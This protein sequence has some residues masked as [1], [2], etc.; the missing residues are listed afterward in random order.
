M[1]LV[2]QCSTCTSIAMYAYHAVFVLQLFFCFTEA[3]G[4]SIVGGKESK[5]HSKAYMAS[6]QHANGSHR[7]GGILIRK[8]FVLTAAHCQ[9]K[10]MTVILG[11]HN[12]S[13]REKS[14]QRIKVAEFHPYPNYNNESFHNDIMLLKLQQNAQLNTYIKVLELPKKKKKKNLPANT[15]CTVAGWG[16]TV[17]GPKMGLVS[18]VLKEATEKIEY[19]KCKNIWKRRFQTERMICTKH[20]Q[21]GSFCWGDSGGPLIC[22]EN[23]EGIVSYALGIDC[24]DPKYPHVF[25]KVRFFLPWIQKVMQGKTAA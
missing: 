21:N 9:F 8:D 6:L 22:K 12:I 20:G 3:T 25:T 23:L 14:Q 17:S 10:E 1:S 15:K 5:P 19:S 11:A 13:Q 7:C 4:S 2:S 24:S 18:D 16:Q